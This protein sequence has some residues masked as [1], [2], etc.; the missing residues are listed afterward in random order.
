MQAPNLYHILIQGIAFLAVLIVLSRFIFKPTL[1]VLE[2]RENRMG[3]D[4]RQAKDLVEKTE[5]QIK[6]YEEKIYQAK[7]KAK[8]I[9]SKIIKEAL[10]KE[11]EILGQAREESSK[12]ITAARNKMLEESKDILRDLQKDSKELASQMAQKI[13]GREA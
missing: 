5:A 13:L 2:E 8:D 6:E 3:G 11:R 4:R 10:T 1:K 9:K 12:I 7:S